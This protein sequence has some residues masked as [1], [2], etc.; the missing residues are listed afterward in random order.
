M[1]PASSDASKVRPHS[2]LLKQQRLPAWQPILTPP[3][4]SACFLVTCAIFIPLGVVI[5]QANDDVIDV[6]FRYDQ[7]NGCSNSHNQGLVNITVDNKTTRMGCFVSVDFDIPETMNPPIYFY[8]KLTNFFQ[9]HRRY[10]GSRLDPQL[11]GDP[12]SSISDADPL[13]TVGDMGGSMGNRFVLNGANRSYGEFVYSPAGLIA[14]SMF[15]DSFTLWKYLDA[16]PNANSPRQLICNGSDFSKYSNYP[17]GSNYTGGCHKKGIAW[18]SDVADK[19]KIP[20]MGDNVW[21]APWNN[22]G[23]TS[24]TT[25]DAYYAN[26]WYANEAGHPLPSVL[27]EDFIV[28]MR[29]SSLPDFRKLYRVID[30]QLPA[31]TYR[32]DVLEFF[33]VTRFGGTKSFALTTLSWLGGKNPFLGTVYLAVGCVSFAAA[34]VFG[35]IHHLCGD[36][37]QRAIDELMH[38]AH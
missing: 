37:T 33:D 35:V 27:D 1:A 34:I 24:L 23:G 36:R 7:V 9:N 20:S 15:N 4:V 18:P 19:F 30:V 21:S 32:M 16:T 28:W 13:A 22:Y 6:E 12:A 5:L 14:W 11:A 31:G 10:Y 38:D 17:L 26:G 8:Y 25:N 29:S 3:H 2:S